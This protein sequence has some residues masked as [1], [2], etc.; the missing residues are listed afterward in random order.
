MRK[1]RQSGIK[2]M[3]ELC[4]ELGRLRRKMAHLDPSRNRTKLQNLRVREQ[5]LRLDFSRARPGGPLGELSRTS[6]MDD[7]DRMLLVTLMRQY[8]KGESP[9]VEGRLLLKHFFD[10]PAEVL[11][12][13]ARLMKDGL[14][15]R[16]G[17]VETEE[18]EGL[19]ELSQQYRVTQKAVDLFRESLAGG[20]RPRRPRRRGYRNH[21]EFLADMKIL[22]D[23]HWTRVTRVFEWEEWNSALAGQARAGASITRRIR[24]EKH[25]IAARLGQ[26]DDRS[27]LP[28]I[29]FSEKYKLSYDHKIIIL[30]LLFHELHEGI[31]YLDVVDLM[32][33]TAVDEEGLI[34]ARGLFR[35]NSPLRRH[36]LVAIEDSDEGRLLSSEAKLGDWVVETILDGEKGRRIS[37]DE[38]LEFHLF[39][40]HLD[41]SEELFDE[42]GEPGR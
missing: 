21:A 24:Y 3:L 1:R 10:D 23:L 6:G 13:S 33:L 29:P 9:Y 39:L 12:G 35:P 34:E 17:L 25:R 8:L 32:K 7:L 19:D 42:F 11:E 36:G 15:L 26:T 31:S 30:A 5:E 27:H 38:R 20:R 28:F 2:K 16:T 18:E 37:A 40:K 22:V 4:E 41:S 14:L